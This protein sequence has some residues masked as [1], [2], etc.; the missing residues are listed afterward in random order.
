MHPNL[1]FQRKKTKCCR[2][3]KL[4]EKYDMFREEKQIL[5]FWIFFRIQTIINYKNFQ[6]L[7]QKFHSFAKYAKVS[8]FHETTSLKITFSLA[9]PISL[10]FIRH[11]AEL[12]TKI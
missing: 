6:I 9:H 1:L 10:N 8:F 3:L 7:H 5:I 2:K 12:Q 4:L 11:T